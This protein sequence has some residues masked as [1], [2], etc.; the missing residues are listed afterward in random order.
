M[1]VTD[2]GEHNLMKD[3]SKLGLMPEKGIKK[4]RRNKAKEKKEKAEK[5]KNK[6]EKEKKTTNVQ[7]RLRAGNVR[8]T[9]P[10]SFMS[11]G[12]LHVS[13]VRQRKQKE[14]NTAA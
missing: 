11:P 7:T 9:E 12:K 10:W 2:W 8:Q 4:R 5:R 6:I 13:F 1:S 3:K 14:T